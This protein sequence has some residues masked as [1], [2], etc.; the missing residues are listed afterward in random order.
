MEPK[1]QE[2]S[3]RGWKLTQRSGFGWMIACAAIL[4]LVAAGFHLNWVRQREAFLARQS[5]RLE[6]YITEPDER[7]QLLEWWDYQ[8][9]PAWHDPALIA[10]VREQP[11]PFGLFVLVPENEVLLRSGNYM[12]HSSFAEIQE[13]MRLFP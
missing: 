3:D 5:A 7:K 12:I 1:K 10:L 11:E 8:Q 2:Q 13:A 6:S 4:I 9:P